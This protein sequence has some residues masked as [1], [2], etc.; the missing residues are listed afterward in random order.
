MACS[1]HWRVHQL[2]HV[3]SIQAEIDDFLPQHATSQV[4]SIHRNLQTCDQIY[5]MVTDEMT[6]KKSSPEHEGQDNA[7]VDHGEASPYSMF[8]PLEKWWITALVAY[9]AMFSTMSS[10]I[11]YPA[12]PSISRSLAVSVDQVNLTVTSYMAIATIAPTLVGDAAD[13]IGR[14]PVYIVML[15]LYIASNVAIA[16]VASYPSLL[17]LRI[18][19]ALAISGWF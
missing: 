9:A 1:V 19:Q 11:Y 15:S 18:L 13:S 4:P 7:A 2:P 5:L 17:G 12:I 16:T 8:L 6:D 14:R 10:F 3:A